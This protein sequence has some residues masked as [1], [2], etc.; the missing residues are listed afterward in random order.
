MSQYTKQYNKDPFSDINV[1][2]GVEF[3]EI[4]SAS[5]QKRWNETLE[6]MDLTHSSKQV[7]NTIKNE[8]VNPQRQNNHTQ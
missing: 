4:P 6:K 5:R 1:E 7:W 2:T 3:Q 8:T